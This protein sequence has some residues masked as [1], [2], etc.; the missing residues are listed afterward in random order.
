M[1]IYHIKSYLKFFF[2]QTPCVFPVWSG[3]MNIQI[4][5]F[6]IFRCA[7]ATMHF[8]VFY[9]MS[10]RG[11]VEGELE[12]VVGDLGAALSGE[13]EHIVARHGA[14]EVTA[15]RRDVALLMNLHEEKIKK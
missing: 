8:A 15:G 4:P 6:P 14:G 10:L 1:L 12:E 5:R 13:D 9:S 3:K 7:V 11:G 2:L